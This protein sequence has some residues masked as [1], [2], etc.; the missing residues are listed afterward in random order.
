MTDHYITVFHRCSAFDTTP[1]R[2]VAEVVIAKQA[3]VEV[4]AVAG[5]TVP[6]PHPR[7]GSAGSAI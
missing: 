5:L 7:P 6:T 4:A 2:A 1:E 3:W